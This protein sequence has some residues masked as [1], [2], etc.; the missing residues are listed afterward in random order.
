[1]QQQHVGYSV[2]LYCIWDKSKQTYRLKRQYP[3]GVEYFAK[4]VSFLRPHRP[5]ADAFQILQTL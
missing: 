5:L 2:I 4:N 1:Q 3:N